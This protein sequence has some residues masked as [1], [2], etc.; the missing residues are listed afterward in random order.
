[1]YDSHEN[2]KLISKHKQLVT[3]IAR[4]IVAL[5]VALKYLTELSLSSAV[6]ILLKYYLF[7]VDLWKSVVFCNKKIHKQ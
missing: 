2:T 1:M 6:S 4:N 3:D 5:R 7:Q